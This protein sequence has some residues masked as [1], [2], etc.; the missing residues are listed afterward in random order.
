MQTEPGLLRFLRV[1]SGGEQGDGA[2]GEHHCDVDGGGQNAVR[3]NASI[4]Q[5]ICYARNKCPASAS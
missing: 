2:R 5:E 3:H 4:V 1:A